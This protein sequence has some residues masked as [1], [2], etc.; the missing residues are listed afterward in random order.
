MRS[1]SVRRT[2]L[3]IAIILVFSSLAALAAEDRPRLVGETEGGSTRLMVE[4]AGARAAHLLRTSG[5]AIVP[6]AT[7]SGPEGR[8]LFATWTEGDGQPWSS[9]SRDAGETWSE[10]RPSGMTL[11]LRD[12]D[13]GPADEM[14]F[15]PSDMRLLPGGRLFLVQFHTI[16]LPE[17]RAALTAGGAEVL[18]FFPDN[19]HIVRMDES[20]RDQVAALEFVQRVEPYHPWYRVENELR[21]WLDSPGG[22]NEIRVNVMA[23]EWGPEAKD[24]IR[25]AA[26][27]FGARIARYWSSGRVVELWVDRDQLRA[28]AAHD[29]VKWIDRWGAPEVDMDNVREDSGANWVEANFGYCGDGVQGEVMDN[30]IDLD[31]QDFDRAKLHGSA[32]EQSHGT[33]SFGVVFGNGARDG[34]GDAAAE[35]HMPCEGTRGFFA[36]N[37]VGDRFA[38]TAEL[39]G[40]PY[41]ASFQTNS[42]GSPRTTSY[43]SASSG[44]DDIILQLD[45]AITQ[46]QSNAGNQDSRPQ[47]WAKNIISVGGIRHY[48]TLD[49]SDDAWAFGASIGPA[50]DGRIKPDVH[51]WYDSIYTTTSGNGYTNFGGTSAATP[52]VAGVL[53]LVVQ[54]WADNVWGTDPQGTTVFEKQPHASTIKALL[55]NNAQQYDFSGTGDDLTR[56][57]QGWGRPSVRIAYERAATSFIV[58]QDYDLTLGQT[59]SFEVYVAEGETEL[60]VTMTYPDPPGTTSASMH[61]INDVDLRVTSPGGVLYHGNVG[62]DIGTHSL[63]GGSRNTI[64]TVENVFVLDPEPGVWTVEVEAVEVNQDAVLGTPEADVTFALVVTGAGFAGECGNGIKELAEECDGGDLGGAECSDAFCDGGGALG[65]TSECTFDTTL[66]LGCPVCGDGTCEGN[67]GAEDCAIDCV[68]ATPGS[69]G[70][71]LLVAGF[72]QATG[73]LSVTYDTACAAQHNVIE[74]G[75]LTAANLQTYAWSGQECGLDESGS[76]DWS[77]GGLPDALFFVIVGQNTTHEGSY[78]TDGDDNERPEDATSTACPLPQDLDLRCD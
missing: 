69:A 55:I 7:G 17:W 66:C 40:P 10:A 19:A 43:T 67:E 76:Y 27:S 41:F 75:E 52:E 45:I 16:S 18:A 54:M 8:A 53:G 56:T 77:V 34:D 65:C 71:N 25:E 63:P 47:A 68:T 49:P 74:Y 12:G 61:R 33:S 39:K 44:M 59:E 72:D 51:Y 37:S 50:E 2:A 6:G 26:E 9:Y 78:G 3:F 57:H 64:D 23:F 21:E 28:L 15:A 11:R 58:D 36:S 20:A 70:D 13:A 14:P 31:H 73:T 24:R 29:D 35:G 46:S 30:G 5:D 38:H 32:T 1:I 48:N 22:D 4:V 42:W 62:L 60:K